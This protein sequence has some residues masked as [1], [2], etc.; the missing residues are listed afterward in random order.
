MELALEMCL[1]TQGLVKFGL[2]FVIALNL[3]SVDL[4]L[5]RKYKV[6]YKKNENFIRPSTREKY[7]CSEQKDASTS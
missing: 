6:A 4:R 3:G 5:F 2:E 1:L 7:K